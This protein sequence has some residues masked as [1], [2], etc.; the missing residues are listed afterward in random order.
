MTG[1]MTSA[2]E[3]VEV[4]T[5]C[6]QSSNR[7][8]VVLARSV[9]ARQGLSGRLA[10][11][12]S[13]RLVAGDELAWWLPNGAGFGRQWGQA[14]RLRLGAGRLPAKAAGWVQAEVQ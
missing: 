13:T 9:A 5:G 4:S 12:D 7:L 3:R 2:V 6:S 10:V 11:G 8:A 1:L 14:E